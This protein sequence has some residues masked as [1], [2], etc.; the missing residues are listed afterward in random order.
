MALAYLLD[1]VFEIQNSAGKPATDGWLE[2]YVHGS[3]ERYY[4]ASDFDGTLHPFKIPLDSLGSNI[5]LAD[6]DKSYDVYVYNRYGSLLMSRYAVTTGAGNLVRIVSGDG[7]ID[8]TWTDNGHIR[9]YDIRQAEDGEDLLD[10]F[11]SIG[12]TR[13]EDT[14]LYLPGCTS[15]T[16]E[17]GEY[18]PR[19]GGSQ[20]YHA[21][22]HVQAVKT[23]TEPY[24]DKVL[25]RFYARNSEGVLTLL[26]SSSC[27][28]DWSQGLTQEFDVSCDLNIAS[29]CEICVSIEG[30]D[31]EAGSFELANLYLHRVYSGTPRIPSGVISRSEV[32]EE[33]EGK[34]DVIDDL[35]EIR[36]GAEAGLTAVQPGD[37]SSYATKSEVTSGLATKQDTL[38]AGNN[39][40]IVDNVIS[41]TGG[42]G[43]GGGTT[44]TAGDGIVINN[45]EISV[46]T[47]VIQEKLTAGDNIT[48][49]DN[50]ISAS[51]APQEQADWA[52]SDANAVDYIKNK[53]NLATVATSGSYNDLSNKPSIPA[54]Q[55]QS[56]WSQSNSEAV[57]Y[58]KNKPSLATVA[59]S[60]SYND[61]SNKPSIPAAQV[62]SD[63]SQSD[64]SKVDFIKNKPSLATV[65]TSGSYND[66]TNKPTIPS[67][68]VQDV[69][70]NGTSVVSNG[71]A[72][73]VVPT[74]VQ[75]DWSETDPAD[76][77]YIQNKPTIPAA[78]VNADWTA[79]SG[80]AEI[81]HKPS[82]PSATSDLTNDSGF[83]TSSD[84]PGAQAQADWNESDSSDPSYIKNKP[85][86]PSAVT[87]DQTYNSSSSNPQS[88]TAVAGALATVNQVPASTSSD[89]DKV[90]TVNSSGNPVWAPAQGGAQVQSDWTESDTTDPAYIQNKPT[91]KSISAGSGI[92]ITESSNS[93]VISA[94]GGGSGTVDQTYNASSTNAQSGTAVAGALATVNQVPASTAS[95][96]DKVLTVNSSGTP[97][98]AAAQ[99]G[100]QV[101]SDW[102][103]S[104][105]TDPSYI[106]NKPAE[107]SL[108]AGTNITISSDSSTITISSVAVDQTYNSAS[109]NPQSGVAVAGALATVRQVPTTQSTDNGKVLGVTDGNGTLGWVAQSGGT[110]YSAGNMISLTNNE[111]AVSTT[112]GITDIQQVAALPANPVSTVLYLIPAT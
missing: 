32:E 22:A 51:A 21:T 56:D 61:L 20:Y 37:L 62:Q 93:V 4:C 53:P 109:T 34:Q 27:I 46:D 98:W 88:G 45:D 25:V 95:D 92:S 43:G 76:P 105:T 23:D 40:T 57:D 70:V 104:D 110:S 94:T 6:D 78:Q 96:E 71:T 42:G 83:I 111:V 1:P 81:L 39:I 86:I 107:K 91:T 16:M 38:I 69:T 75:A 50:T 17:M 12:S 67:V 18:G 5:V 99:G 63:W 87:V 33:L 41:A 36:A 8:V 24:Y 102:S 44:Y 52:Q 90:L 65:A 26:E 29:D 49:S 103:E 89:E 85:T 13:I 3:R 74:Q 60:G 55:V 47:D 72:A 58:I 14:N 64:S 77:S 66:L 10:W 31:V 15:G 30:Q 11:K 35:S 28:V 80:V 73:V 48:I 106:Q 68:P 108:V 19:A 9:T 101:Q 2:V 59:T 84:V 82:I 54:A 100:T 112:A 7:S 97:V 79:S